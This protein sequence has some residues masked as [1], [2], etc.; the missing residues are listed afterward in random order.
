[1]GS[2]ASLIFIR[3]LPVLFIVAAAIAY[4]LHVEGDHPFALRNTMPM[5]ALL[6]LALFSL[7]AGKGRLGRIGLALADWARWDSQF[8][9]SACHCISITATPS[10]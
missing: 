7:I 8:R 10:T 3:L 2:V 4:I 1:M 9:R 5:I 6:A